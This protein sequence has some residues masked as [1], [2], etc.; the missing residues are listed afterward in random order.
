MYLEFLKKRFKQQFSYRAN[1]IL[2]IIVSFIRLFVT[3]SIWSALYRNKIE[4]D[5]ISKSDMLTYVLVVQFVSVFVELPVSAYIAQRSKDGNL[6]IDLIRP[7]NLKLCV[8]FDSLGNLLYELIWY[9][10]P[11]MIVGSI[12]WSISISIDFIK[13]IFFILSIIIAMILYST[14]EYIMGLTSFWTKTDF[15]IKWIIGAFMTLFS[16]EFIPLWF[17]PPLLREIS[18]FL[19]FKY[20]VFEPINILL[21]KANMQETLKIIFI[22]LLW[23][24]LLLFIEQ[25][26]WHFAEKVITVQGG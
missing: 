15:H 20:F 26:V 25:I 2:L 22:Q 9:T 8:I 18:N 13:T 5:G 11:M 24:A 16:G 17:Y 14:M 6:S 23:L 7:I 19:P 21:G 12:L 10:I 4:V 1:T 3:M